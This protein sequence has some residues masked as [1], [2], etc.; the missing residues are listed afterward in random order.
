MTKPDA[1]GPC[2]DRLAEL[3]TLALDDGAGLPAP[4]RAA[5]ATHLE[6]CI[7][8]RD[9]VSALRSGEALLVST[10]E[11]PDALLLSGFAARTADA[12]VAFRDGSLRG[13]WWSL[14]RAMRA[15]TA[16]SA[17]ALAAS[18]A[19]VVF[20]TSG[21]ATGPAASV[22]PAPDLMALAVAPDAAEFDELDEDVLLMP[23]GLDADGAFEA[24]DVEALDD[25]LDRVAAGG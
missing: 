5:L 24:L 14:T 11:E 18:A 10:R 21:P 4:A 23:S 8:C 13:W 6:T 12:A 3:V 15:A 19:L 1:T 9:E 25:M 7:G 20:A 17:A 2:E 22:E 16:G